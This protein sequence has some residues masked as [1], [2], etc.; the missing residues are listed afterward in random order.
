M[1]DMPHTCRKQFQGVGIAATNLEVNAQLAGSDSC[2]WGA[3]E[4]E[5]LPQRQATTAN[6][7][8]TNVTFDQH[9]Y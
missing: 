9:I 5:S 1:A 3:C 7:R 6:R 2:R 8:L 4:I